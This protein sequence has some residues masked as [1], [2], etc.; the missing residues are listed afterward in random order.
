MYISVGRSVGQSVVHCEN[1]TH[2]YSPHAKAFGNDIC[3]DAKNSHRV[4][5]EGEM[6]T[7]THLNHTFSVAC[8]TFNCP[9][10]KVQLHMG[11]TMMTGL[12]WQLQILKNSYL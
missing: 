12:V 7:A 11:E 5:I 8:T 4:C 2:D 1:A 6:M 3:C 10:Y 9:E